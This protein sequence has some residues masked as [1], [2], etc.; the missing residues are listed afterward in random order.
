MEIDCCCSLLKGMLNYFRYHM[1]PKFEERNVCM[2]I[3]ASN[4]NFSQLPNI[5]NHVNTQVFQKTLLFYS[6]KST[7]HI[8]NSS[9]FTFKYFQLTLFIKSSLHKQILNILF[10]KSSLHNQILNIFHFYTTTQYQ[11]YPLGTMVT[12]LAR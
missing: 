4:E 6:K 9:Q 7:N 12:D 3:H 1:V 2:D 11:G 10:I 8:N 5:S